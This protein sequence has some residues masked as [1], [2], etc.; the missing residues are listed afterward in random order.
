MTFEMPGLL[1]LLIPLTLFLVLCPFKSRTAC[2]L[3]FLIFLLLTAALAGLSFKQKSRESVL[4]ILCDRSRSMPPDS[5]VRMER[6]IREISKTLK[7]SPG[8]ISF[9]GTALLEQTP[10]TGSFKGFTSLLSDTESSH[11]ANA[12]TFA[13]D[14]IPRDT[15]GRILLISDGKWNGLSPEKVFYNAAMRKIKIDFLPL[16]REK[17]ADF[18]MTG[19]TAP[20]S[21]VP[22]ESCALALQIEAPFDAA[23]KCLIRKNKGLPQ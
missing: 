23:V 16:S 18:A 5:T 15:P 4:F 1:L 21:A 17:S 11:I 22:G 19:L 14:Q 3:Q 12:L 2:V 13:L 20:A 7:R 8:I 9:A 6:Q 10:G